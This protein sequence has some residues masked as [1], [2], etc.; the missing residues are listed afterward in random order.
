RAAPPGRQARTAQDCR[1]EACREE[2][3]GEEGTTQG[4]EENH[5]LTAIACRPSAGIATFHALQPARIPSSSPPLT[6]PG[7]RASCFSTALAS[8]LSAPFR[9]PVRRARGAAMG[10][11]SNWIIAI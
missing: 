7:W 3:S 10:T 4:R 5:R 6:A 1:E 2:G 11:I 8:A 9:Y